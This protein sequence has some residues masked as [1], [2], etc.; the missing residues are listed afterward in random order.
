M[1][2]LVALAFKLAALSC[3]V[4]LLMEVCSYFEPINFS[5]PPKLTVQY[6]FPKEFIAVI[7]TLCSGQSKQKQNTWPGLVLPSLEW[8]RAAAAAVHPPRHALHLLENIWGKLDN[9]IK[10]ILLYLSISF[11]EREIPFCHSRQRCIC[12]AL[13]RAG[14]CADKYWFLAGRR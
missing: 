13:G 6:M 14:R 9:S 11:H 8:N 12:L 4:Y 5:R 1:C 10:L 2:C 7:S 3:S